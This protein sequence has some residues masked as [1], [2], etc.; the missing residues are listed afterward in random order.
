MSQ[1]EFDA[2]FEEMNEAETDQ[3]QAG[4]EQAQPAPELSEPVPEPASPPEP[5]SEPES[6]PEPAPA[7]Q[8]QRINE[9]PEA[10]ADELERLRRLNPQ[11]ADLA[12]EDSAEG[13]AIRVR[14]ESYGAEA[15]QDR[16]EMTLYRREEQR[17]REQAQRE[18]VESYNRS[19]QDTIRREAPEFYAMSN[20]PARR[21]EMQQ[22]L[23]SLTGWIESKPFREGVNLM[24]IREHGNA[25]EVCA[26][27]R[28]FE[29]EKTGREKA[30]DAMYAVPGRG[31]PA[32]PAAIGDK[33]DFDAGWNL[34]Q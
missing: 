11:A 27:I 24:R 20:D 3:E 26:L 21:G 30:A 1:E 12:L 5:A 17:R 13:K 29:S 7:S 2:G 4:R 16:A 28:Q 10:I 14:L 25:H 23:Q 22:Y 32:A 18:Q 33:N 34:H 8:P 6:P 19:F 15:A 9:T 31:A